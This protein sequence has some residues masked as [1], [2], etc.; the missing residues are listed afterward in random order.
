M[1]YC[2]MDIEGQD[3]EISVSKEKIDAFKEKWKNIINL[4]EEDFFTEENGNP[5]LDG[6]CLV[7]TWI[8]D[9]Q[10]LSIDEIL[11]AK[12]NDEEDVTLPEYTDQAS[13]EGAGQYWDE[14]SCSHSI[15]EKQ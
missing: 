10:K 6:E 4:F 11:D 12:C 8:V 9:G 7:V 5:C 3:N 1:G 15:W 2:V 14:I 13:C